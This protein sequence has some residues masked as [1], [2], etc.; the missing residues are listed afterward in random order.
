MVTLLT[1][2]AIGVVF[3]ALIL[4][5]KN[6]FPK[7]FTEKPVVMKEASKLSYFL[8][9]TIF[10]DSIQPVLYGDLQLN[11]PVSICISDEPGKP[12]PFSSA[13]TNAFFFF[14]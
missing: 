4:I 5:N 14:S 13:M 9:A 2:T 3:I 6:D 8:A 10:L 11:S 1:S 12:V 7:V